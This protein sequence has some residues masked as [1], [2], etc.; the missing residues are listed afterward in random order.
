MEKKN[1][2]RYYKREQNKYL[3]VNQRHNARVRSQRRRLRDLDFDQVE[4]GVDLK[5][6]LRDRALNVSEACDTRTS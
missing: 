2:A 3:R 5:A 1:E 4:N 6:V